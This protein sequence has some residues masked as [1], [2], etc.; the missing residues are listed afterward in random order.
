MNSGSGRLQIIVPG[1][2]TTYVPGQSIRLTVRLEDSAAR[3]WGFELT[4]RSAAT[5]ANPSG[6]IAVVPG[7]TNAQV[8]GA[9][10]S[11]QHATHTSP[12]TRPDTTGSATWELD[13]TP[14]ADNSAVT[15]YAAG[16]AANNSGNNQGDLIYTTSLTLQPAAGTGGPTGSFKVLPQLAFGGGWYTSMYFYNTGDAPVNFPV[17]FFRS[18]GQTLSVGGQT[19]RTINLPAGGTAFVE[20]PNVGDLT[21]GWVAAELPGSVIGHGVFRSSEPGR[22]NQEAVVPLSGNA[23]QRSILLFDDTTGLRT[24]VAVANPTASDIT[25]TIAARDEQGQN[26]GSPLVL[27]LRARERQAFVLADRPELTAIVGKRGAVSF[28]TPTGALS[29]L[30]LRFGGQA[31]TSI[32]AAER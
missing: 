14:P 1:G 15:F 10:G 4:S 18:D 19:T 3:R 13:W 9:T 16:N 6:T 24:A 17:Y 7:D 25:V 31:F 32:P 28:S 5:P 22:A 20:A 8:V 11:V 12:G 29:V 30:G 23:S 2:A 21:Q 27:N 26:L